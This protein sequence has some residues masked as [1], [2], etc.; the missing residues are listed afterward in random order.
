[1]ADVNEFFMNNRFPVIDEI[2]PDNYQLYM[3][4][5]KPVAWLSVEKKD[6]ASRDIVSKAA[7]GYTS[8]FSTV[9]VDAVKYKQ[10][11]ESNLG[12]HGT[13]GLMIVDD[14]NS[15]YKFEMDFNAANVEAYFE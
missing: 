8:L 11:V 6:E 5:G 12:I 2:G 3:E 9:W 7:K 15:K 10:H 14:E 1:M 4:R 13:P